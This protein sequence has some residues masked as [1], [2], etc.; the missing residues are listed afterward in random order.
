MV[1]SKPDRATRAIELYVLNLEPRIVHLVEF[2]LILSENVLFG[3]L[4]LFAIAL[5]PYSDVLSQSHD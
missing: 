3:K 5:S 4:F 1:F 2:N